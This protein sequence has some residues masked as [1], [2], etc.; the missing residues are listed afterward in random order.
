MTLLSFVLPMIFD[1]LGLFENWHPRQQ[2]RLQLARIMILNLLNLYSLMFSFIYKISS[3]DENL[4][5]L[6]VVSDNASIQ[7]EKIWEALRRIN[8]S[9]TTTTFTPITTTNLFQEETQAASDFWTTTDLSST[10]DMS[11]VSDF[12]SSSENWFSTSTTEEDYSS[13]S[14][15]TEDSSFFESTT[16]S[17]TTSILNTT[18][19]YTII[20]HCLSNHTHRHLDRESTFFSS[21]TMFP[22][23]SGTGSD[24]TTGLDEST[25]FLPDFSATIDASTESTF[26]SDATEPTFSTNEFTTQ[27]T[28]TTDET[29]KDY[30]EYKRF[31]FNESYF[32][33]YDYFDNLD[34]IKD[35]DD[36]MV[37]T[38][39]DSDNSIEIESLSHDR[40]KR[41][42]PLTTVTT[43]KS[44][45]DTTMETVAEKSAGDDSSSKMK[46]SMAK[47][48]KVFVANELDW[49]PDVSDIYLT[50]EEYKENYGDD[51]EEREGNCTQVIC[52]S[53]PPPSVKD[54]TSTTPF[55]LSTT[56]ITDDSTE[57]TTEDFGI[58]SSTEEITTKLSE[59]ERISG[60]LRKVQE[61]KK[62]VSIQL[63]SMCW[64]TSLGQ[65]LMKIVVFDTKDL[66]F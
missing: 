21:T 16:W 49:G 51:L 40:K 28:E 15:T 23:E 17:S 59:Y 45:V 30:G 56:G 57:F 55:E 27:T 14:S 8:D 24:S 9:I 54:D 39:D 66:E 11:S 46:E 32:E 64:E 34:P 41:D 58:S 6:K 3:S 18:Y 12:M 4:Q 62:Y 38:T 65:E 33:Y 20:H 31:D 36:F 25:T 22:S 37:D 10:L 29:T 35:N 42:L 53:L 48:V 13:A 7:E 19:C 47:S 63:T 60:E 52:V 43:L 26:N 5:N 50:E 1:A 2:L 44:L 61:T